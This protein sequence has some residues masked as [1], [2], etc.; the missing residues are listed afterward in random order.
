M[1]HLQTTWSQQVLRAGAGTSMRHESA[2]R[3]KIPDKSLK[4]CPGGGKSLPGVTK[5]PV[6]KLFWN[7]LAAIAETHCIS[8]Q[9]KTLPRHKWTWWL[10]VVFTGFDPNIPI[11]INFFFLG[12]RQ[13]SVAEASPAT[14]RM[15]RWL[16]GRK[17]CGKTC[18]S[19][20]GLVEK[21]NSMPKHWIKNPIY[22]CIYVN[23]KTKY[24]IWGN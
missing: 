11:I 15:H 19:P 4:E 22:I 21:W 1:Q 10:L 9:A 6:T 5:D 23:Y 13:M 20:D 12:L 14:R 3:D 8:K 17:H 16:H 7:W 24:L 2:C 18:H